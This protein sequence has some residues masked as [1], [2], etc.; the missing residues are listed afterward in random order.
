MGRRLILLIVAL[1]CALGLLAIM[2][3]SHQSRLPSVGGDARVV[4]VQPR[5][6]VNKRVGIPQVSDTSSRS[7][8]E[9]LRK[10]TLTEQQLLGIYMKSITEILDFEEGLRLIP[11]LCS[12]GYVTAGYGTVLHTSKGMNP[13]DF[14]IR[15]TREIALIWLEQD[16]EFVADRL[17]IGRYNKVFNRLNTERQTILISMAY[18]MGYHG[19]LNFR[20][21]WA[22]LAVEDW[23]GA[24]VHALDSLWAKQTPSRANRHARVLREGSLA[25]YDLAIDGVPYEN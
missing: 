22:A 8:S 17:R 3:T 16:V 25:L 2:C 19:L 20:N 21:M 18:Q 4:Y 10:E 24:E 11:Y 7:S 6:D 15:L 14:P 12:E 23:E 1:T 9:S 13:D 5:H